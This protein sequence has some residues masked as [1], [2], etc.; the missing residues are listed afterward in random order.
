M[1]NNLFRGKNKK[2]KMSFLS[3]E[4]YVSEKQQKPLS[5]IWFIFSLVF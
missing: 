4:S 2:I 1:K 5:G 3:T